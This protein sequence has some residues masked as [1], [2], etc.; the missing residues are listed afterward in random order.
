VKIA[1]TN[2]DQELL[3]AR[4]LAAHRWEQLFG[5][6]QQIQRD[7]AALEARPKE[8]PAQFGDETLP[9]RTLEV[10]N[11]DW[12]QQ[13]EARALALAALREQAKRERAELESF[14]TKRR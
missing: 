14:I 7:T 2:H 4:G 13:T 8:R 12:E 5:M 1:G 11:L 10:R 3:E 9:D 6:E